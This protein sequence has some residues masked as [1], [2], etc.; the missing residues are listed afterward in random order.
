MAAVSPVRRINL[1]RSHPSRRRRQRVGGVVSCRPLRAVRLGFAGDVGEA[2]APIFLGNFV[3]QS[4]L[5][6]VGA[7]S[8]TGGRSVGWYAG[9][10]RCGSGEARSTA[11]LEQGL[12]LQVGSFLPLPPLLRWKVEDLRSE[13]HWVSSRPM[14][15]NGNGPG[16]HGGLILRLTKQMCE[17]ALSELGIAVCCRCVFRLT[18]LGDGSFSM[19]ANGGWHKESLELQLVLFFCRFLCALFPGSLFSGSVWS[20]SS[21]C[22]NPFV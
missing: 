21:V 1:P 10:L 13:R 22:C 5:R 9:G 11:L 6:R 12:W 17:S 15:H 4:R 16:V 3:P 8:C 20:S 2:A 19:A 18:P 14:C 7:S